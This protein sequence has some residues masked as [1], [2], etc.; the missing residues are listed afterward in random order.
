MSVITKDLGVATAYGYAKSKGYTGTEEEF[1]ELMASY[2]DVAQQAEAAAQDAE[3]AK[4]AAVSAKNDAVTAKTA[5]ESAQAAAA[6]SAQ[7]ASTKA[8][9]ASN[10]AQTAAGSA[11]SAS[12]SATVA[13]GSASTAQTAAQTATSKASEAASSASAASTAK[14]GAETARTGAQTAQTAAETAQENAEAAASSVSASA[15]QIEQN[16]EEIGA[17]KNDFNQ[18]PSGNYPEMGAG[19]ANQLVSGLKKEDSVP[20]NFRAVPYDATLE[21]VEKIVGGT[22]VNN[23]LSDNSRESITNNGI[24][25]TNNGNGTIT[26]NGTAT[27]IA[28]FNSIEHNG[29]TGIVGHVYFIGG[30]A[31]SGLQGACYVQDPFTSNSKVNNEVGKV[32]RKTD[33]TTRM[34]TQ[35][36]IGTGAIATNAVFTPQLTDVT[37]E[38]GTAIADYVLSLETATAGAGVAWLKTHF[39]KQFD[40]GYQAYDA[41][42]MQSVS[43]LTEHKMT[44]FNQWDEQ[45]ENGTINGQGQDTVGSAVRPKGYIPVFPNT[46]YYITPAMDAVFWYDADKN[47]ISLNYSAGVKTSPNNAHFVRFYTQASYGATYNHDICINL[48]DPTKNGTY[49]PY[50]AH[51]YA[52]DSDVVLRG[53]PKLD[54]NNRL[55]YD[56]DEYLPDGTVNRRY[57][58]VKS[59]NYTCYGAFRNEFNVWCCAFKVNETTPANSALK[60]PISDVLASFPDK[61]YANINV[62]GIVNP[63]VGDAIGIMALTDATSGLSSTSTAQQVHTLFTNYLNTRDASFVY[64]LAIPATETADPYTTSQIIAPDGTEEYIYEDD[65]FELPVGHSSEYPVDVSGQLD[66]ILDTPSANGTYVLKATV[67][68]GAVT[69]SWVADA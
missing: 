5:A 3:D 20:Y 17:L 4:D 56:G 42:S 15:A 28:I 24:T 26:A 54:S 63:L 57:K 67:A 18:F 29:V 13:S 1:A 33:N 30:Y 37:A 32:Y 7:T 22:V 59:N 48:S 55:Y 21:E 47:F 64:E 61:T 34:L 41:G 35:I 2:A 43:G 53:I 19:Y 25:F 16:T 65:A 39:P 69:Y 66:D 8:S 45:W 52:L 50:E 46:A 51:E 58:E 36:Y 23:Q 44:G 68:D 11:T 9:E 12:D 60:A 40:A 10:S 38:F 62:D 6:G 14:T 31:K 49:E 27:D